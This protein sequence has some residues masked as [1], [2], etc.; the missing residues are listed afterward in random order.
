MGTYI[1]PQYVV[2]TSQKS[3]KMTKTYIAHFFEKGK[4]TTMDIDINV[5]K[6]VSEF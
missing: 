5:I 1:L 3:K 2:R 4:F 6:D